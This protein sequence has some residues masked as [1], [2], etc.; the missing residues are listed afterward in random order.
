MAGRFVQGKRR[1]LVRIPCNPRAE[2]P[3]RPLQVNRFAVGGF[4]GILNGFRHGWVWVNRFQNFFA[5]GFELTGR[6]N[7]GNHFGY[8]VADKVLSE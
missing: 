6:Y 5:S 2:R 4:G 3:S 8:V 1:L 7:F